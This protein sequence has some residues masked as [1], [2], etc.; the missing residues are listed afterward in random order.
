M[1]AKTTVLEVLAEIISKDYEMSAIFPRWRGAGLPV[2]YFWV[3][4]PAIKRDRAQRYQ[5]VA[6]LEDALRNARDGRTP[7]RCHVT[8]TKR[9]VHGF[10]RWIDGHAM[11]YSFFLFSAT[12]ALLAG[13]AFAV[14]RALHP[15]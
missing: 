6:E 11:L 5:S 3:V 2:D 7:V 13:A 15:A 9:V 1:Q 12:V 8:L 10:L 4:L 14:W